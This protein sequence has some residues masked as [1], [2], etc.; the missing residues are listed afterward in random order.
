VDPVAQVFRYTDPDTGL[1]REIDIL[2]INAREFYAIPIDHFNFYVQIN[3]YGCRRWY[4]WSH[5]EVEAWNANREIEFY[6]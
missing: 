4:P 6:D 2:S 5:A 3:Q 1:V